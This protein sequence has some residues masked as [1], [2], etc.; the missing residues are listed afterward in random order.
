[1]INVLVVENAKSLSNILTKGLQ[2]LNY[3]CSNA[4]SFKDIKEQ[5]T[6]FAKEDKSFDYILLNLHLPDCEEI[7]L[8]DNVQKLTNSKLIV[9]TSSTD[10]TLRDKLFERGVI[11]YLLKENIAQTIINIDNLI[12]NVEQNSLSNILIIDDS[13]LIREQ[14]K[15]I[16]QPRSYGILESATGQGG[17]DIVENNRIDLVLLD[18]EL[19]DIHGLDVLHK[20]KSN[21]N[22]K[23]PILVLSGTLD[24]NIIS[25]VLKGGASDFMRK[26]LIIEEF[27]LKTDLWVDYFRKTKELET[28]KDD[29]ISNNFTLELGL[30]NKLNEIYALNKEIEDTQKEVISTMGA[31]GERRSKETGNHVKRVAQYSYLLAVHYGLSKEEAELLKLASPMHDIGKVAIP[32]AV[33]NKPGRFNEEEREIMNSHPKLGYDMLCNSERAVM[34]AAATVAYEHHEKWDGTGYPRGLVG[35][36]IHI[37]GRITAV[38][39]VFDALGSPRVYKEAW[40]DEKIWNFLKEGR[41]TQFD[42]R[43]IDIFFDNLDEFLAVREEYKDTF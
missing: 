18:M 15:S 33:L 24:A 34:R 12:K 9:L 31:I 42:A 28:I 35:E 7:E 10:E 32:D 19:D 6:Q 30:A 36:D 41:N 13:Q 39:D 16:L 3:N 43:L 1:M 5:V 23:F 22:N 29:L 38:A 11:D 27:L 8:V 20:I 25:K 37:Y 2:D 14:I 4:F 26:P 40:S 21:P 17:L